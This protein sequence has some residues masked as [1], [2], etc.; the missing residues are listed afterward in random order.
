VRSPAEIEEA[1]GSRPEGGLPNLIVI[2]AV[3]CGTSA[4]HYYLDLHP[5][6]AM[7]SPKELNFFVDE[8]DCPGDPFAPGARERRQRGR[9][10]N[11]RRGTEWY[12]SHFPAEA[13]V[14]GESS[15]VYASPWYP[16]VAERIASVVPDARL[17]FMTRDP[18]DRMVSEY[19]HRR[20]G[21]R[22][23]RPLPH[24]FGGSPS[25]YL[26]RSR[27]LTLLRPF[28]D[29]FPRS[30]IFIGRQ[31]DLLRRR[32]ETMRAI[33]RF[34]DVD[35]AFWS[36]RM[37]RL[38]NRTAGSF[39]R[40]LGQRVGTER[41]LRLLYGLPPEAK[42]WIERALSSVGAAE[43]RPRVPDELRCRLLA[44][45]EGE[46]AGLEELTGWNLRSWREPF[47]TPQRT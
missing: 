20:A 15:P 35:Q 25:P 27:Y 33:F 36:E 17:I 21:R 26:A 22:E 4:L 31:E 11:W 41:S 30:R 43:E 9:R 10:R 2:G 8:A 5:E 37:E 44:E 14:R 46:M 38:R 13:P 39:W 45:L 42:W 16:R 1:R 24:A 19:A 6:I 29:Q 47:T 3:K 34:L 28:L 23:Q 12:A 7:S 18:V 40:R 32:Q